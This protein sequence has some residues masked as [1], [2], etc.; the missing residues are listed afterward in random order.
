MNSN[1]VLSI[2][3]EKWMLIRGK[4]N[5]TAKNQE[6]GPYSRNLGTGAGKMAQQVQELSAKA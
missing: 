6:T 3:I 1:L 2:E 5:R 4:K